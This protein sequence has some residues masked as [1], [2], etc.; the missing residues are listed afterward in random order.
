MIKYFLPLAFL[1]LSILSF[2]VKAQSENENT[3]KDTRVNISITRDGKT[4]NIT[5]DPENMDNLK[6]VMD[7][8]SELEEIELSAEDGIYEVIV[9]S[10]DSKGFSHFDVSEDVN[11][12]FDHKV[13]REPRAFLGV[14]GK[15]SEKG[16]YLEKIIGESGAEEAGL[17]AGDVI[18][19]M[20]GIKL[21]SYQVFIK[22]IRSK[23]IGDKIKLKIERDGKT[24]RVEATLGENTNRLIE[25]KSSFSE[26]MPEYLTRMKNFDTD[27][28][29]G[30]LGIEFSMEGGEGVKVN[31]VVDE[32][33]AAKAGLKEG[34]HIVA[35]D[36]KPTL[37]GE[38]FLEAIRTKKKGDK[39]EL[40]LQRGE[41][42]ITEHITL[43]E[44]TRPFSEKISV[45]RTHANGPG[46]FKDKDV[47]LRVKVSFSAVSKE[48]Q[49]M[50]NKALGLGKNTKGFESVDVDVY[51]NPGS[52]NYEIDANI[53]EAEF[54]DVKVLDQSGK[55]VLTKKLENSEGHFKSSVDISDKANGLYFLVLQSGERTQIEKLIKE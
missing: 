6:D 53:P 13:N 17:K 52:G 34:D 24:K 31:K 47:K 3:K 55:E 35:I 23:E 49:K 33:P 7:N 36:G 1:G 29:R 43:T 20:D 25:W 9:R 51:P 15:A 11:V 42:S 12:F 8:I 19:E 44:W 39:V 18:L 5:I 26:E 41:K 37:D 27:P 48:E 28:D 50:V 46:F 22:G 10:K 14:V 4:R 38:S 30:Y 40:K 21:E 32:S 54:L 45:Y 2:P 16:I